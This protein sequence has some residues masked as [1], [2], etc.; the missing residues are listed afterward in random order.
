MLLDFPSSLSFIVIG[1]DPGSKKM[2][3]SVLFFSMGNFQVLKIGTICF[4][5]ELSEKLFYFHQFLFSLY[6]S[7]SLEYRCLVFFSIESQF[8]LKNFRS[9]FVLVSFNAILLYLSREKLS[10]L[11]EFSPAEVR[12][13]LNID[14]SADKIFVSHFLSD[15]FS[16]PFSSLDESD[17]LAISFAGALRFLSERN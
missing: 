12:R 10:F 9:S 11:F 8:V 4:S 7:V 3:Y 5:G 1:I 17:S 2:G 15:F 14:C 13:F 16:F 6:D